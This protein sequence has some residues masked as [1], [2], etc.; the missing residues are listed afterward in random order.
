MLVALGW[1]WLGQNFSTCSGLGL[2]CQPMGWV[3]SGHTKWTHGQLWINSQGV[4]SYSCSTVTSGRCGTVVELLKSAV[5][6]PYNDKKKK[7]K[8]KKKNATKYRAAVATRDDGQLYKNVGHPS[9]RN[10]NPI[11]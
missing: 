2:V 8:Q 3:G 7:K 1:V 4:T 5:R 11:F 10:S 9:A 6:N